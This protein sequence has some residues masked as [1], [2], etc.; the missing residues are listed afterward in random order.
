[1]KN[2]I[3]QPR[4]YRS[5]STWNGAGPRPCFSRQCSTELGAWKEVAEYRFEGRWTTDPCEIV[6]QFGKTVWSYTCET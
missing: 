5:F 2:N 3:T 4:E 1:M 6:N